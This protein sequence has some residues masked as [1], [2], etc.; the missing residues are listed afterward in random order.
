MSVGDTWAIFCE[1]TTL[2]FCGDCGGRSRPPALAWS[3]IEGSN[4]HF[5]NIDT[6]DGRERQRRDLGPKAV[7]S[8]WN[9][10]DVERRL[11][12]VSEAM[13]DDGAAQRG[14]LQSN[15]FAVAAEECDS[16]ESVLDGGL[17]GGN[18]KQTRRVVGWWTS[19]IQV[20]FGPP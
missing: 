9:L 20:M 12:C 1:R 5:P 16:S 14:K 7:L 3:A 8:P 15:A 13:T 2:M 10:Q 11:V 19:R 6:R 18:G 17:G 4:D